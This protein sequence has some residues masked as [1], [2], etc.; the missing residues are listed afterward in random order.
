M[1]ADVYFERYLE[2][3]LS[4]MKAGRCCGHSAGKYEDIYATDICTANG[5][6]RWAN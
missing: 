3:E 2:K 5:P 4:S 1:T 6:S